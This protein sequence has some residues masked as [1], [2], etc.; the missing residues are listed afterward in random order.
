MDVLS[1]LQA[2]YHM[3]KCVRGKEKDTLKEKLNLFL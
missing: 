1:D 3:R 2:T